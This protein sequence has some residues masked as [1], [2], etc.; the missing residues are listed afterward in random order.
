MLFESPYFS[1]EEFACKCGCGFGTKEEDIAHELVYQLD[2]MRRQL[3]VP[4]KIT[5]AARCVKHNHDVGGKPNST[6]LPGDP[7]TCTP[8]WK[9]QSRAVD[10]STVTWTGDQKA[11]AVIAALT[12]GMRVG[13]AKSFLHFDVE[14]QLPTYSEKIW[15]YANY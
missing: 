4:F 7:A 2:L 11:L 9:G 1:I 13:L 5:S 3:N 10:I 14:H 15:I 6:H 12:N 8:I